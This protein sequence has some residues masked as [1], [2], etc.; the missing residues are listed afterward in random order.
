MS[1]SINRKW[2]I[3]DSRLQVSVSIANDERGVQGF[4]S[5]H[6]VKTD[7]SGYTCTEHTVYQDYAKRE[8]LGEKLKRVT[9]KVKDT[10][11]E[12]AEKLYQ[13][14]L[15]EIQKMYPV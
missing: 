4:I 10:W 9:Q 5:V 1:T 6:H 3:N 13:K 8:L 7:S 15:P 2:Y 14:H 12:Q 11:W